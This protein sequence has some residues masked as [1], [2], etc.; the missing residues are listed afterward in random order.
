MA[1]E[2]L[3]FLELA[4]SWEDDAALNRTMNQQNQAIIKHEGTLA[5][6]AGYIRQH[7]GIIDQHTAQIQQHDQAIR[8]LAAAQD[9]DGWI[10]PVG[11][12]VLFGLVCGLTVFAVVWIRSLQKRIKQLERLVPT[13]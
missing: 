5:E 6:Y 2:L 7:A 12:A 3:Q 1:A 10:L 9:A 13:H 8:I 4:K 11:F